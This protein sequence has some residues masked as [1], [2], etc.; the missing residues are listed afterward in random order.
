MSNVVDIIEQSSA[1]KLPIWLEEL[2]RS[3]AKPRPQSWRPGIPSDRV[4]VTERRAITTPGRIDTSPIKKSLLGL[5]LDDNIPPRREGSARYGRRAVSTTPVVSPRSEACGI[6]LDD[7]NQVTTRTEPNQS[8][9]ISLEESWSSLNLFNRRHRGRISQRNEIPE[10]FLLGSGDN[11]ESPIVESSRLPHK[12]WLETSNTSSQTKAPPVDFVI[13]ELPSGSRLELDITSTWGDRHYM[14]LNGVEVFTISGRLAKVAQIT[15][16]PADINVLPEYNK[17]PRVVTNLLDKVNRTRDDMHLWLTPFTEGKHHRISITFQQRETLAMIRI[18]NY[19][20]SRIHSY[21][22][23][24]DMRIT[25]DEQLI[26][27]GEIAR[28][29]GGILGSTDAFGDTILFTTDEEILERVSRHDDAFDSVLNDACHQPLL[30]SLPERPLTASLGDVR[31]LTCAPA[32]TK[33]TTGA[34]LCR[35]S[36]TLTLLENWGH[37]Q[38]IGLTGIQVLGETGDQV[39]VCQIS[40]SHAPSNSDIYRL[41]DDENE[42]TDPNHMWS[43]PIHSPPPCLRLHL[44]SPLHISAVVIWNYNQ[45]P[46]T[47]FCG[48]KKLLLRLDNSEPTV[49]MLRKAPGTCHHRLAQVLPLVAVISDSP[50]TNDDFVLSPRGMTL[51]YEPPELPQ[52]F[53]FELVLLSSCGDLYYIGLN[54]LQLYNASGSPITLSAS[55]VCAHPPSVSVLE[56][57][58]HDVRTP[59]KLIDGINNS[60]DGSHSWLAPILP[61]ERNRIYIVFDTPT[62]VSVI[63]LWN[64]TKTPSRGVKEFGIL[65]DDLLIYNGVFDSVND[66][67]SAPVHTISFTNHHTSFSYDLRDKESSLANGTRMFREIPDQS[68]RPFTSLPL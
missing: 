4:D 14:G 19:N 32:G 46:E 56:G 22:G 52:G 13:P 37:S 53:V 64:Y 62:A 44:P 31:P 59:E 18:W 58:E 63:K 6:P 66:H 15:A 61:G 33:M 34:V 39:N 11:L 9:Q 28:A 49:H 51:D 8:N 60:P 7:H 1:S 47:S 26:F 29:C 67:Q 38:L 16:E 35:K 10:D 48:V 25:L 68:Q 36:L 24:K 2:T 27:Q 45:S 12:S 23:A 17:D 40:C 3:L 21:R 20:K 65:V 43:C 50:F 41:L 55:N 54:G 57:M 42:T 30:Q 5:Q